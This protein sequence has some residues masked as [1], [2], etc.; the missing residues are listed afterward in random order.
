[1]SGSLSL[2]SD[3]LHSENSQINLILLNQ[4]DDNA[5]D[6]SSH[7]S[8]ITVSH[9]PPITLRFH[10]P[11]GYPLEKPPKFAIDCCWLSSTSR[12]RLHRTLLSMWHRDKS[13]MLFTW[14][15]FLANRLNDLTPILGSHPSSPHPVLQ[16]YKSYS[17]KTTSSSSYTANSV[18]DYARLVEIIQRFDL[19]A[20]QKSFEKA[21]FS[22][23]ICLEEKR[24][25][26]CTKL[27]F[28]H[29]VYCKDC[30]SNFFSL[31]I[32][33]GTIDFVGCPHADCARKTTTTTTNEPS[34]HR[35]SD[36]DLAALVGPGLFKR[37]EELRLKRSLEGR[38]DVTYCPR[39]DCQQPCFREEGE[40]K[41]VQW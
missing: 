23:G 16:F 18:R 39:P 32:S 5:D 22:C 27:R 40:E 25:A 10:L 21:T 8:F 15:D 29:H 2:S 12:S 14:A 24:G 20:S 31:M 38:H 37:F 13:V 26:L 36:Q 3:L 41:F 11:R 4:G 7:A 33:D 34:T 9:L 30:L 6:S 35:L 17:K 19:I 1:M 28:C